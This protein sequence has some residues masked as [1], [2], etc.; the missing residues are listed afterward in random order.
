MGKPLDSLAHT[1]TKNVSQRLRRS[2]SQQARKDR[3]SP[4]EPIT[5][6]GLLV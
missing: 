6:F 5:Q 4:S 2:Q 3:N 1:D